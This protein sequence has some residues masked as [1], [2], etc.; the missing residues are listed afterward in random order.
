MSD[1]PVPFWNDLS[2]VRV[3]IFPIFLLHVPFPFWLQYIQSQLGVIRKRRSYII[4]FLIDLDHAEHQVL[5]LLKDDII[6]NWTLEDAVLVT[7]IFGW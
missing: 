6:Y 5:S 1:V 4:A 3:S 7:D 2:K